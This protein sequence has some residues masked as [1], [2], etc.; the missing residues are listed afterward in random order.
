N[1]LQGKVNAINR[2][3]ADTGVVA[4]AFSTVS[5]RNIDMDVWANGTASLVIN[6]APVNLG[7]PPLPADATMSHLVD[8]FNAK[9]DLTG[10]TASL[11]GDRIVLQSDQGAI[12]IASTGDPDDIFA[13]PAAFNG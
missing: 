13:A 9:T 2:H 1:S 4:T 7:V 8:A 6:G 3:S 5:I 12:N 11:L 10:V